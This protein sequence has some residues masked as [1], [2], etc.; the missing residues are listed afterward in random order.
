MNFTTSIPAWSFEEKQQANI[1]CGLRSVFLHR[2]AHEPG[3]HQYV[4]KQVSK[5]AEILEKTERYLTQLKAE[6]VDSFEAYYFQEAP[7]P[8]DDASDPA[9]S[10]I[11]DRNYKEEYDYSLP[12]YIPFNP[13]LNISSVSGETDLEINRALA[14]L[15]T[16]EQS[17][18]D[19]D[20]IAFFSLINAEDRDAVYQLKSDW[21]VFLHENIARSWIYALDEYHSDP[22]DD[23]A[24]DNASRTD[25]QDTKHFYIDY[26]FMWA[27]YMPF[28]K[29]IRDAAAQRFGLEIPEENWLN[30]L[31]AHGWRGPASDKPSFEHETYVY[32]AYLRF[33]TAYLTIAAEF[34]FQKHAD[35]TALL[36]RQCIFEPDVSVFDDR[37]LGYVKELLVTSVWFRYLNETKNLSLYALHRMQDEDPDRFWVLRQLGDLSEFLHEEQEA[38]AWYTQLSAFIEQH[39]DAEYWENGR[40]NGILCSADYHVTDFLPTLCAAESREEFE[41]LFSVLEKMSPC[42]MADMLGSIP[43]VC[44]SCLLYAARKK[45]YID[46]GEKTAA[47]LTG[48]SEETRR[49]VYKSLEHQLTSSKMRQYTITNT[50]ELYVVFLETISTDLEYMDEKMK[51]D[52]QCSLI[53]GYFHLGK[54]FDVCRI[55]AELDPKYYY[56]WDEL[57]PVVYLSYLECG[58]KEKADSYLAE[59]LKS[60]ME[61]KKIDVSFLRLQILLEGLAFTGCDN[62]ESGRKYEFIRIMDILDKEI[63]IDISYLFAE[64]CI[65][66]GC[67]TMGLEWFNR[68]IPKTEGT[69]KA[70]LLLRKGML[71]NAK[72]SR[73][74]AMKSLLLAKSLLDE[75]DTGY[76][77]ENYSELYREMAKIHMDQ[78]DLSKSRAC[79]KIAFIRV[80]ENYVQQ[81]GYTQH[82]LTLGLLYPEQKSMITVPS[83]TLAELDTYLENH[84]NTAVM[85]DCSNARKS[86]EAA[87]YE[88][89]DLYQKIIDEEFDF[90]GPITKYA[91]ALENMLQEKIWARV[92]DGVHKKYP[93]GDP[94][95]NKEELGWWLYSTLGPNHLTLTLGSWA[96]LGNSLKEYLKNPEKKP[97]NSVLRLTVSQLVKI[98]PKEK[99]HTIITI[100]SKVSGLRNEIAHGRVLTRPEYLQEREKLVSYLNRII[101]LLWDGEVQKEMTVEER[102]AECAL[103]KDLAF[104]CEHSANRPH[105][106]LECLNRAYKLNP[107]DIRVHQLVK[108][109]YDREIDMILTNRLIRKEPVS[110]QTQSLIHAYERERD[111]FMCKSGPVVMGLYYQGL[112][113][114]NDQDYSRARMMFLQISDR[115]KDHTD[116][117]SEFHRFVLE[118][119]AN[120]RTCNTEITR[121]EREIRGLKKSSETG[122]RKRLGICYYYT[123]NYPESC[124]ILNDVCSKGGS[125]PEIERFRSLVSKANDQN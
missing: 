54:Y 45:G 79:L 75:D 23:I 52:V 59:C 24:T 29:D 48:K 40:E 32:L 49:L 124:K 36:N 58:E 104:I 28:L 70:E 69:A 92:V 89:L 41:A 2:L 125:D 76:P 37:P 71:L 90:S 68:M 66:T 7:A 72:G 57:L 35:K 81:S 46:I 10:P 33:T 8:N 83:V 122:D 9:L 39:S 47:I 16:R 111:D 30:S 118:Y 62:P 74:P 94:A 100:C 3:F 73:G 117:K 98:L 34:W 5:D 80:N 78:R 113:A 19:H 6:W 61:Y 31:Y 115:L 64:Y 50:C 86:I 101:V 121:A 63:A 38:D 1:D 21:Q 14:Y 97:G 18:K 4:L 91:K 82:E 108:S 43:D 103:Q 53:L 95:I 85:D 116:F 88:S 56:Y 42:M 109:L 99:L 25:K 105:L 110:K 27:E 112:S 13:H 67:L 44:L 120:V 119:R 11:S 77:F 93:I 15:K 107:T 123:G 12:G 65:L 17:W 102:K 84:V 114:L 20:L 26:D 51:A 60:V 87:E 106:A 22:K 96:K 55:Y